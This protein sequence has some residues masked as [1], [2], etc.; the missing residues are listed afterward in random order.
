MRW[1]AR[2]DPPLQTL[3]INAPCEVYTAKGSCFC[4]GELLRG[5][6]QEHFICQFQQRTVPQ[7]SKRS[8]PGLVGVD[9]EVRSRVSEGAPP[10]TPARGKDDD[11]PVPLEI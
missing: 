11:Q 4:P 5:N 9:L 7:L 10:L 2:A 1:T 8:Q 3:Q 6:P